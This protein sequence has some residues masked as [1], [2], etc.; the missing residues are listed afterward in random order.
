MNDAS[1]VYP[2]HHVDDVQSL[3]ARMLEWVG[4][5]YWLK[6]GAHLKENGMSP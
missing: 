1:V 6:R 2:F 5:D 3:T 4:S